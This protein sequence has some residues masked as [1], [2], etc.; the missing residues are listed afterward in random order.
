MMLSKAASSLRKF[1]VS[2]NKGLMRSPSG[3]SR[4][5]MVAALAA[6]SSGAS[7]APDPFGAGAHHLFSERILM[8]AFRLSSSEARGGGPNTSSEWDREGD[9]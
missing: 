6:A 1:S 8:S 7:P 2:P 9:H 4:L 5:V 3:R